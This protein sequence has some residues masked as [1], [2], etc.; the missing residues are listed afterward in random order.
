MNQALH[1]INEHI[2]KQN[3]QNNFLS[4]F[5]ADRQNKFLVNKF[6]NLKIFNYRRRKWNK[7]QSTALPVLAGFWPT[8]FLSLLLVALGKML[9]FGI[10]R[11]SFKLNSI[12][13]V[14]DHQSFTVQLDKKI[15]LSNCG[16][17]EFSE[18][19]SIKRN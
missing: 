7:P 13:F 11:Y 6:E 18:K 15:L 4:Y 16:N 12:W 8:F 9:M 10:E 17:E 19:S 5:V 2:H 1:S 3:Q 14:N